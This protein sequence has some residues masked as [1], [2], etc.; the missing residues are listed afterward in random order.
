MGA[1]GGSWRAGGAGYKWEDVD[2]VDEGRAALV[3]SSAGAFNRLGIPPSA[4]AS[5]RPSPVSLG[6]G[7]S[8]E[9]TEPEGR[10]LTSCRPA[11]MNIMSICGCTGG[12]L[13]VLLQAP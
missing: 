5:P 10:G 9:R 11:R 1:V 7:A 12:L 2:M 8:E 3:A 6:V 13:D 4:A